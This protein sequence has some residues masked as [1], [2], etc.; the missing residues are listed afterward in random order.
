MKW[1][2]I[3][4]KMIANKT[5]TKE[6]IINIKTSPQTIV[7]RMKFYGWD[8]TYLVPITEMEIDKDNIMIETRRI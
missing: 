7:N 5:V 1:K 3:I 8:V 2:I 4:E 6:A